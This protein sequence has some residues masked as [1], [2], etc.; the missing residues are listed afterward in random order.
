VVTTGLINAQLPRQLGGDELRF[1]LDINQLI[2][3]GLLR[4][5]RALDINFI[6]TDQIN[7][8]PNAGFKTFDGLG[9]AGNV[10]VTIPF[11]VNGTFDNGTTGGIEEEDIGDV[12]N[13]FD[14]NGCLDLDIADWSV[15]VQRSR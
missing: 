7:V 14:I 1:E 15:E 9:R 6:T 10:F 11:Q 4:D 3:Q 12:F 13:C 5:A 2:A 8:N